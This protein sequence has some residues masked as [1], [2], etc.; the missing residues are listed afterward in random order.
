MFRKT[1]MSRAL[2][3]GGRVLLALVLAGAL[4]WG[5]GYTMFQS[6]FVGAPASQD[7]EQYTA[8][9]LQ[10]A[11]GDAVQKA[12]DLAIQQAGDSAQQIAKASAVQEVGTFGIQTAG[13]NALQVARAF[14]A[15]VAGDCSYQR[16]G[17]GSTQIVGDDSRQMAGVGTIQTTRWQDAAGEHTATRIV[18]AAEADK[19]YTVKQGVWALVPEPADAIGS[20]VATSP[21]ATTEDIAGK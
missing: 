10:T 2:L 8:S 4:V 3:T 12:G 18:T 17:E 9:A 21:M 5:M 19:L 7:S 13:T 16:A 15:Q 1:Q 20:A 11:T 6:A 14:A